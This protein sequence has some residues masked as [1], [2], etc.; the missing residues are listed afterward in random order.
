MTYNDFEKA[1]IKKLIE[2]NDVTPSMYIN[3]ISRIFNKT[4][5]RAADRMDISHG[6]RHILVQLRLQSRRGA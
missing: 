5:L 3:D 6:Y 2:G 1:H 4:V